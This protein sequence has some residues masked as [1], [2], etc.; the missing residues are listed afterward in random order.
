MIKR[1]F[2]LSI[3][4]LVNKNAVKGSEIG[5]FWQLTDIHMN[6]FYNKSS[7]NPLGDYVQGTPKKLVQTVLKFMKNEKKKADFVMWT[8]DNIP[9][10]YP[11][12][13]TE[14]ETEIAELTSM[15]KNTFNQNE[16]PIFPVLGN[17]DVFKVDQMPA[18]MKF[19]RTF[20]NRTHWSSLID[21]GNWKAGF[22]SRKLNKHLKII[23]LNTCLYYNNDKLTIMDEDP[24]GQFK[25]LSQQLQTIKKNKMKALITSH[26]PPGDR[27]HR[28]FN[29][30]FLTII[31]KHKRA[32][33]GLFFG[34]NHTDTFR[35]FTAEEEDIP[36]YLSPPLAPF[37]YK[38]PSVRLYKYNKK[39]G[40][41]DDI[42]QYYLNLTD[43]N[44]EF[45]LEYS[46]KAT[47]GLENAHA[48]GVMSGTSL[49]GLDICYVHF[50][51]DEAETVEYSDEWYEK[52][53]NAGSLTALGL[54]K[55]NIDYG[56]FIG[57]EIEKFVSKYNLQPDVAGSHGHTIF[58]EPSHG[59]TFQLGCGESSSAYLSF[60]LVTNFRMKDIVYGGQG[61]P[62]VPSAER[63]LFNNYEA[64]LNLG[65]IANTHL[66]DTAFDI[67]PCNML[68]NHICQR[69][70]PPRKYDEDGHISKGGKLVK[71]YEDALE[72]LQY[73]QIKPPKSTGREWF[74]KNVIPIIESCLK[75]GISPQ[76]LL[77][78]STMHIV[79]RITSAFSGFK[80]N[81]L[82]TGGGAFNSFLISLLSEKLNKIGITLI[83]AEKDIVEYKEALIFA[84]FAVKRL[85]NE[86]NVYG[87]YTGSNINSIS[88]A[89]H[90]GSN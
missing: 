39:T 51:I 53:F 5:Y 46:F 49:D 24:G 78:T 76:D 62:L 15:I 22:Y 26:V 67:C 35:V 86:P 32:I 61:A 47:Y 36:M 66:E 4:Y 43:K 9:P 88:G 14:I 89:L 52:L 30:K 11:M 31:S 82:I 87:E 37:L 2:L 74:E 64:C 63:F 90:S 54:V 25:W 23:V 19:Y 40:K 1:L 7:T 50:Y 45:K 29:E 85:L 65:G 17:H 27:F 44:P 12:N 18:D 70:K 60:P 41:I 21:N 10:F 69:L 73:Y 16:V 57:K 33:S 80:G 83:V 68:L 71:S 81:L 79:K 38:N 58:H 59:L 3:I 28:K 72:S 77:Y 6:L 84:F 55:L 34:H 13:N 56:H 8:G 42:F 75:S 48:V 20:L